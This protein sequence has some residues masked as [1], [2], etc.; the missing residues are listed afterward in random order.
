[1]NK[2][3]AVYPITLCK[4]FTLIEKKKSFKFF[5]THIINSLN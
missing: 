1:M 3:E 2:M 4:H 5:S